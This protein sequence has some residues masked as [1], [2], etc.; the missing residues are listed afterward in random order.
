MAADIG[1]LNGG[2]IWK[3]LINNAFV[4]THFGN[5]RVRA[6]PRALETCFCLTTVLVLWWFQFVLIKWHNQVV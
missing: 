1:G 6:F 4:C 3:R 2:L 5:L